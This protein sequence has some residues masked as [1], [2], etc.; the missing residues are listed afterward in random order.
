[1]SFM[2]SI[3]APWRAEGRRGEGRAGRPCGSAFGGAP[4]LDCCC[5]GGGGG[6][7]GADNAL[8]WAGCSLRQSSVES[9]AASWRASHKTGGN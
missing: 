5:G 2:S 6:G 3:P 8:A 7:G 1:M 9:L 4:R